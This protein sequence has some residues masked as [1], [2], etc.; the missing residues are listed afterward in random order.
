M[1]I[2]LQPESCPEATIHSARPQPRPQPRSIARGT[3][4]GFLGIAAGNILVLLDGSILN[5]A[6]PDVRRSLGASPGTL[7]WAVDAY[8]VV[9]AGLMLA[10]GAMSDRWG[11]GRVYRAA[12]LGFGGVSLLCALAPNIGTLIAGRA[13]LGAAAAGLVP[14]SLS[15]LAGLYPDPARRTKAIGAWASTTTLGLFA[16]PVLGGLLVSLDGWRLVFLVN[17]PIAFL[18]YLVA[19]R[20]G[21]PAP[22]AGAARTT[23]TAAAR[24]KA[25]YPGLLLSILGLGALTFALV[26]GGTAGWTHMVPLA[27]VL[28]AALVLS[29]LVLVERRVPAPALPGALLSLGRI[30]VALIGAVAANFAYYGQSYTITQWLQNH[31]HMSPLA[32]GLSL[33][34]TIAPMVFLPLYT[35]RL[36]A[37]YSARPIIIIALFVDML[38]GLVL[39]AAGAHVNLLIILAA[40]IVLVIGT[41]LAVPALVAEM[42]TSAP[43]RLAATGQGALNTARQAGSALGVAVLGTVGA[44]QAVGM[45][46]AAGTGFAFLF[47]L[48]VRQ[49]QR[50]EIE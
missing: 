28:V 20:L 47:A 10:A 11:A 37:R 23:A 44:P 38:S 9:F 5:V 30:R 45:V 26:D 24:T 46:L 31:L 49:P 4:I 22:G 48:S 35:G 2:L 32:T 16:G 29:G 19:R 8:T 40:Q 39:V 42:S 36:V 13:L 7:P 17:P 33:L 12:L 43:A 18:G 1:A 21:G 25:D 50:A 14:S 15:L 41:T 3:R 34:P 27:A 6:L